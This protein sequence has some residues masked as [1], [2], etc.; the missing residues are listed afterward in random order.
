LGALSAGQGPVTGQCRSRRHWHPR[1]V[2]RADKHRE[3]AP[4]IEAALAR[5]PKM[6]P[7]DELKS[8]A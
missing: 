6:A 3:L 8:H 4:Y 5:K 7:L 1:P 2:A